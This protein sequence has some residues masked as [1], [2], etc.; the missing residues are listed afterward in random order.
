M[1]TAIIVTC[2]VGLAAAFPYPQQQ[3]QLEPKVSGPTTPPVPIVSYD[4]HLNYDGSYT[5]S[6][7]G[8]DG[9]KAVQQGSLKTIGNE[10]GEVSQGSYSYVGDDGRT[11]TVEYVA[12][13]NGYHA[14]GEHLPQPPPI[15]EAIRKSL[16]YLA[17]APPPPPE[18]NQQQ[19]Q[20]NNQ[21]QQY[22]NQQQ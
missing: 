2:L 6:F 12:D 13:E 7:E 15:P 8:G 19:Q 1:K 10:A 22:N 17:T 14:V 3:Q 16:E 11:Y 9:T 4:N 21:Q 5:Y 20:Y 18:N